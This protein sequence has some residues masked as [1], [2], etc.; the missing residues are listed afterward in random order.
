[1]IPV[2][3]QEMLRNWSPKFDPRAFRL[4]L[5][6]LVAAAIVV[7]IAL[8]A[9]PFIEFFNDMAVQPKGKAQG[10]Y[11]RLYGPPQVVE[12]KPPAGTLPM[13]FF[14]YHVEAKDEEAARVAAEELVNPVAPTMENLRVGQKV[15]AAVCQTCHG[16]MGEGNGPIVGPGRFPAPPSLHTDLA[17]KFRDGRI[18]HVITRGQNKMPSHADKLTPYERWC[19]VLYVRAL[20]RAMDPKPEDFGK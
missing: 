14:P 6:S 12:R 1:M 4:F 8:V 2:K 16:T 18:F 9:M 7:P 11:G 17:K 5:A 15:F 20:Q 3:I 19:A 13:D 10:M